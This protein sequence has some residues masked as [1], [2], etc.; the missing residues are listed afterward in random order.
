M[1]NTKQLT[2]YWIPGMCADAKIFEPYIKDLSNF[3]HKVF[4]WYEPK[5]LN[6]DLSSYSDYFVSEIV[7]ENPIIVGVSFGGLVALKMAKKVSFSKIILLSSMANYQAKPFLFKA[8]H[9]MGLARIVSYLCAS[10]LER[11]LTFYY[12]KKYSKQKKLYD[13]FLPYRNKKYLFW[14]FIQNI[15]W[16]GK[17]NLSPN[18]YSIHGENDEI[19]PIGQNHYDHLVEKASHVMIVTHQKT[20]KKQIKEIVN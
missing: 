7:D 13:T 4:N 9:K 16:M 11:F 18:L 14:A 19:F 8:L 10:N 15:I 3:Q 12:G 6:Q 1:T 2:I 17:T 20:I 5:S